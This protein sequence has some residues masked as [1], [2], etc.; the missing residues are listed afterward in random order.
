MK[1]LRTLLRFDR[2]CTLVAFSLVLPAVAT[3]AAPAKERAAED[4][5]TCELLLEGRGIEKLTLVNEL[6][7]RKEITRPGRSVR[8]PP[9]KYRIEEIR[10]HRLQGGYHTE[11]RTDG[12]QVLRLSP[13]K[14][15]RLKIGA[16]LPH[17]T[18]KRQGRLL[19][20]DCEVRDDDGRKYTNAGHIN[21]PR[22][23]IYQADQEIASGTF[24]Y[25]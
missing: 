5:S 2:C 21:P 15:C 13:D 11:P 24:E 16:I 23:T 22:F 19:T 12:Q 20:L 3:A 10:L 9:G 1:T 18:A 4:A 25:G 8:L 14:P 17:V 7:L 6:G